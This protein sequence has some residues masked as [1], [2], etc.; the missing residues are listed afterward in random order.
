MRNNLLFEELDGLGDRELQTKSSSLTR[1]DTIG[2][3][4]EATTILIEKDEVINP[5]YIDH[6]I[7]ERLSEYFAVNGLSLNHKRQLINPL[8]K[9]IQQSSSLGS[10]EIKASFFRYDKQLLHWIL[11][12]SNKELET[13]LHGVREH[14][15]A[16]HSSVTSS[17]QEL[18]CSL[19]DCHIISSW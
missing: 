4:K 6:N 11:N 1:Y 14:F 19:V 13:I 5:I 18:I 2:G 12:T 15:E 8:Q 7:Y 17:V 3:Q 16:A 9:Q 10:L